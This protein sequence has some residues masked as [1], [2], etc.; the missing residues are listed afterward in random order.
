M[1]A[2]VTQLMAQE[3]VTP[4]GPL[5]SIALMPALMP[6]KPTTADTLLIDDTNPT[7]TE[8][9][10]PAHRSEFCVSAG[11]APNRQRA[12]SI[13]RIPSLLPPTAAPLRYTLMIDASTDPIM[14]A[15]VATNSFPGKFSNSVVV[16]SANTPAPTPKTT[17]SLMLK[18]ACGGGA[19]PWACWGGG[20]TGASA[21]GVGT[22][23]VLWT[24]LPQ[25]GQNRSSGLNSCPQLPQYLSGT[26]AILPCLFRLLDHFVGHPLAAHRL[27]S[28]LLLYLISR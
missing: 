26:S 8:L 14:G 2:T 25:D 9:R 27:A 21:P 5:G 23:A 13:P 19:V 18:D 28:M 22:C 16:R 17:I 15:S 12:V 11:K 6:W 3:A 10:S 24:G 7:P 4:P 1:L 20:G